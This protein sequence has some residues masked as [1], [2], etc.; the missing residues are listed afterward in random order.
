MSDDSK[1]FNPRDHLRILRG[2]GGT[3]EYLE[4]GCHA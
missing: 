4:G 2:K 3:S 1:R